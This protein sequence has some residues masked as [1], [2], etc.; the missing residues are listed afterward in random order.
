MVVNSK[1]VIELLL[2][3]F[4]A[5]ISTSVLPDDIQFAD[6]LSDL[7][8]N[9]RVGYIVKFKQLL[10]FD[11]ITCNF[12]FHEETNDRKWVRDEID[13]DL[14]VSFTVVTKK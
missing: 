14:E 2:K 8:D 3:R 11:T 7:I 6:E 4:K 12:E 10:E 5:K 1:N 13:K 9:S